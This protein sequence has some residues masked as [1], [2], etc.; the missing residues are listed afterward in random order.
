[1]DTLDVIKYLKIVNYIR[2][3]TKVTP[4]TAADVLLLA[5]RHCLGG[6]KQVEKE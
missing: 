4:E 1:M 6:L 3:S 2:K 5:D